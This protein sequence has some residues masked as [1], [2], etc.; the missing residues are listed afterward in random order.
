MNPARRVPGSS[1]TV[2]GTP[3][4]AN[5][6]GA[7]FV[8]GVPGVPG[9]RAR[10]RAHAHARTFATRQLL[11][12]RT[13]KEHPEHPVQP[14]CGKDSSCSGYPEQPLQNPEQPMKTTSLRLA[15]PKVTEWIDALR[16][17]FGADPINAA[18]RAGLDGQPTFW[19]SENGHEIGVKSPNTGLPLSQIVIG[20]LRPNTPASGA[21]NDQR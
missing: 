9:F 10:I 14:L 15:M 21:E 7:R 19:A 18:I 17:T 12:T 6:C 4:S 13:H 3:N 11:Y 16:E 2:P 1:M 8:R 20:P 5:P